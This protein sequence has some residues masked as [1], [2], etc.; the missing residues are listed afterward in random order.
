MGIPKVGKQE[1]NKEAYRSAYCT[2]E[3]AY[4]FKALN[5][6]LQNLFSIALLSIFANASKV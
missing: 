4:L 1:V 6:I 5:V 2:E 3:S